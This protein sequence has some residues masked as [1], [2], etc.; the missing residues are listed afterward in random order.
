MLGG[1]KIPLCN[2]Q[3]SDSCYGGV[4]AGC[5]PSVCYFLNYNLVTVV[6]VVVVVAV[7]VVVMV[8]VVRE[9]VVVIWPRV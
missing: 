4:G 1:N 7:V 6:V 5:Q 2:F 3:F 8:A 9:A